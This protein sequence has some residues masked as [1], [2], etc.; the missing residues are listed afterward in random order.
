MIKQIEYTDIER[1]AEVIRESFSTVAEEFGLNEQ[2]C[3]THTSF[4]KPENLIWDYNNG[5]LMFAYFLG[6]KII[7]Y[8][9]LSHS[10][11][12]KKA[13]K[14]RNLAVLPQYRH[15]GYG[16]ELVDFCKEKVKSFGGEKI[17]IGIIEENTRLKDWYAAYGFVHTGTKKFEQFPFTVGFMELEI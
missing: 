5:Y 3:P 4:T 10:D 13:Y 9:S 11:N 14:L 12:D 8:V 2:N 1:C 16:R 7:G 6:E 15:A 17:D